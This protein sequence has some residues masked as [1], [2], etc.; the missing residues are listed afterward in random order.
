MHIVVLAGPDL[1][2]DAE[3]DEVLR[4]VVVVRVS[5]DVH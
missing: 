3:E 4:E 5:E 1:R 2:E